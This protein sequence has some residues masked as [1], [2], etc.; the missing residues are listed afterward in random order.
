MRSI[1]LS[2]RNRKCPYLLL[3]GSRLLKKVL[4]QFPGQG[5]H[6]VKL[7]TL[8]LLKN[9]RPLP[10]EKIIERQNNKMCITSPCSSRYKESAMRLSSIHHDRPTSP[11]DEA[12][13]WI[14]FTM[15]NNGAKHLR[16]QAHELTWYQYHSLDVLAFLLAVVLLITLLFIRTCRYCFRMCCG[17]RGKKKTE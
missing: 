8:N 9:F 5:F 4:G 14:E 15:R 12:L 11:L 16:V 7:K 3:V 10:L 13:F 2:K 1:L 17:R 6:Q